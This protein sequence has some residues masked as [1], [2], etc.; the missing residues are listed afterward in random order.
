GAK[1][2]MIARVYTVAFEG[3]DTREV[4]VQ[5]QIA[6]GLPAFTVVG[7]PDKAVAESRE[8]VDRL[9]EGSPPAEFREGDSSGA[10]RPQ[11]DK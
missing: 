9:R 4:D 5:V 10:T 1:H 2:S 8:R 6:S 3:V 7:L 11:N